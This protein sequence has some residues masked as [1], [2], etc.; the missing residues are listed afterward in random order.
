MR[1]VVLQSLVIL[2]VSI[3]VGLPLSA[4]EAVLEAPFDVSVAQI[5]YGG[6]EGAGAL[7]V[8]WSN[9]EMY[10]FVEFAVDGELVDV[11]EPGDDDGADSFASVEASTGSHEFAVRG[12]IGGTLV[13]PWTKT[14]FDVLDESPVT[15]P[16]T[17]VGCEL[18]LIH[19]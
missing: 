16:I 3:S 1:Q 4:Q 19:I 13:S 11:I 15:E 17:N 12:V 18:S 14:T 6:A 9:P 10:D 2:A 7:R 5:D 8:F